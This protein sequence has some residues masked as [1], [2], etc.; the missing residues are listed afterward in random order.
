MMN[1]YPL[2]KN[3][4]IVVII[5]IGALYA[6]PN[7][8][9]QD[10]SIEISASRDHTVDQALFDQVAEMGG[11]PLMWR[12]GHSLIKAKMGETGALLAGEMSGHIF[13]ADHYYGY[14]DALY[15]GVRMLRLV[16]DTGTYV[17][18]FGQAYTFDGPA[19][20]GFSHVDE[21]RVRRGRT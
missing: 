18:G 21:Q 3:I 20:D 14:D 12:T 10:P 5:L 15:A 4:A 7:V 9:D 6:L 2:W 13:F 19:I 11:N 8:Y 1:E 16:A 17:R